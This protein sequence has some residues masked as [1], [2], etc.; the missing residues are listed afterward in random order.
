M[1]QIDFISGIRA[2]ILASNPSE[3]SGT[4]CST[5]F[6]TKKF[7]LLPTQNFYEFYITSEHMAITSVYTALTYWCLQTDRVCT[8]R[9]KRHFNLLSKRIHEYADLI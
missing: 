5:M 6:N 4:L 3:A 9:L 1:F 7:C 2:A 8:L